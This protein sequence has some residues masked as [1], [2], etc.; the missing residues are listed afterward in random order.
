MQLKKIYWYKKI[1]PIF[2]I[3]TNQYFE[4]HIYSCVV[5]IGPMILTKTGSQCSE[6]KRM[7]VCYAEQFYRTFGLRWLISNVSKRARLWFEIDAHANHLLPYAGNAFAKHSQNAARYIWA[8]RG[9]RNNA[10]VPEIQE[11]IRKKYLLLT[12]R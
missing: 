5:S 4:K 9:L 6:K 1:L 3:E 8:E 10:T 2:H 12:S 7:G 11:K